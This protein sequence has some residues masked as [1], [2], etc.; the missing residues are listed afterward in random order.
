MAPGNQVKLIFCFDSD[1]PDMPRAE[2]MWV[3]VDEVASGSFKGTLDNEPKHMTQISIGDAV[4][5]KACHIINTD[6]DDPTAESFERY[7]KRCFVTQRILE[8]GEKPGYVYREPPERDDDSGWR[9]LVGDES[10]EYVNDSSNTLYVAVGAVLN[11]DLTLIEIFEEQEGWWT[12][13]DFSGSWERG[14]DA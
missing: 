14:A 13:N 8:G 3:T 11:L 9:F 6:I 5:F 12:W 7:F 10:D 1:E 2:R 4:Q